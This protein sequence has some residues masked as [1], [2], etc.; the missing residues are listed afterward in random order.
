[1]GWVASGPG[2]W[3]N[4]ET[5]ETFQGEQPPAEGALAVASAPAPASNERP[6]NL[7]GTTWTPRAT[8]LPTDPELRTLM[9]H[10]SSYGRDKAHALLP[11]GDVASGS[12]GMRPAFVKD[13][14][15]A[16]PEAFRDVADL[17]TA[18]DK[19]VINAVNHND[20]LDDRLAGIRWQE[21]RAKHGGNIQKAR[22][23]WFSGNVPRYERDL[24]NEAQLGPAE[25]KW[26]DKVSA[27]ADEFHS[28]LQ[29]Q[30]APGASG[31]GPSQTLDVTGAIAAGQKK[32]QAT[33]A[34]K[35]IRAAQATG[36]V[37]SQMDVASQPLPSGPA[38]PGPDL[39][40][41]PSKVQI[42]GM[43]PGELGS[44]LKQSLGMSPGPAGTLTGA[45]AVKPD[46]SGNLQ[47]ADLYKAPATPA[48]TAE[49]M[50]KPEGPGTPT[51]DLL[52][53]IQ[54]RSDELQQGFAQASTDLAGDN[55]KLE[56]LRKAATPDNVF[57]NKSA[58]ARVLSALFLGMG[59]FGAALTHGPNQALQVVDQQMKEAEA[60]ADAKG[61]LYAKAVDLY[62]D[63]HRAQQA[64][65]MIQHDT[66]KDLIS[67]LGILQ[68]GQ[69]GPKPLTFADK[70]QVDAFQ[71]AEKA[72]DEHMAMLKNAYSGAAGAAAGAIG[73]GGP[74]R[75]A[76]GQTLTPETAKA[77]AHSD[78]LAFAVVRAL[79]PQRY[80]KE[81][82]EMFRDVLPNAGDTPELQASKYR[83]L[84]NLLKRTREA[85]QTGQYNEDPDSAAHEA[86]AILHGDE[87]ADEDPTA[88]LS[89]N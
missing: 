68:K 37:P 54:R 71:E 1:M 40:G 47:S 23:E 32:M 58:G 44:K 51:G 62:G 69:G 36:G 64:L 28:E 7:I 30:H 56:E 16:H 76:I 33:A 53:E 41:Q 79:H 35:Y 78:Q 49:A 52:S 77:N 61:S 19:T 13:A 26:F 4:D 14:I 74:V 18:D 10:E 81:M 50:S 45:P 8:P 60:N 22:V 11:E 2:L 3:I 21:I 70:N 87:G 5:G 6:G 46:A 75:K 85:M 24:A 72:L 84:R 48:G 27:D 12:Y 73:T 88:G 83:S 66:L 80:S 17:A 34:D 65:L 67:E 25:R 31:A 89:P 39:S 59:A 15:A 86:A 43:D 63:K 82:V 29:A 42:F 9:G 20:D 55:A 57:G 38:A